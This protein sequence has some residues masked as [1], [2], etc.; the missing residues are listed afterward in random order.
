MEIRK[1]GWCKD[2]SRGRDKDESRNGGSSVMAPRAWGDS[3][4][5]RSQY[6]LKLL[7]ASKGSLVF[8]RQHVKS[9]LHSQ[10]D[11]THTQGIQLAAKSTTTDGCVQIANFL[12]KKPGLKRGDSCTLHSPVLKMS[13]I[14]Q[15]KWHY[16]AVHLLQLSKTWMRKWLRFTLKV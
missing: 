6:C 15:I 9:K 5:S 14:P 4:L 8:L 2:K 11:V 7:Q 3:A 13:P 16:L 10:D 1:R 12:P